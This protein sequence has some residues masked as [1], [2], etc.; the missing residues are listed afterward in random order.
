VQFED[1]GGLFVA[2][3]V[4]VGLDGAF[5]TGIGDL[6]YDLEVGN[7]RL[8]DTSAVAVFEAGKNQKLVNAR[9]RLTLNNGLAFGINGLL[10]KVPSL[11]A[12]ATEPARSSIQEQMAGAH[13]VYMEKGVHLLVESMLVHHA[14]DP[15]PGRTTL[16]VFGEF[17]YEL[18][19]FTP[20]ARVEWIRFP[21]EGDALYQA[22]LS[23]YA[24]TRTL[25]DLRLGICF[26]AMQAL[27]LKIEGERLERASFHQELLTIKAAFGF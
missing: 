17:G 25:I 14:I 7:G 19:K 22:P 5:E 16:S 13:V 6:H 4:G 1:E 12:T 11:L 23:V 20:Y 9:L 3:L 21:R 27:A 15:G 2:H 24:A 10:D 18:G 26:L 8:A